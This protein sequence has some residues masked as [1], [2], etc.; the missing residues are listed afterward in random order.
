MRA[1]QKNQ[2]IYRL[3]A[4]LVVLVVLLP[5]LPF[6]AL[7]DAGSCGD[8]LTWY[9]DGI[10]LT[11]S[12][13]GR[14]SDYSEQ[15]PAP[16]DSVRDQ[17]L[18]I[19]LPNGLTK[20]GRRAF[21]GC[22]SVVS[23]SIPSSVE[24]IGEAA[25]CGNSNMKSLVL[26]EGL[27][28]VGNSAFELC[29]S[30]CEVQI[31]SS[32]EI[33][34]DHAFYCCENLMSLTILGNVSLFGTGAFSYC[35]NLLQVDISTPANQIPQWS[36]YGCD[37]LLQVNIQGIPVDASN[38]KISTLPAGQEYQNTDPAKTND[39]NKDITNSG[40]QD[41]FQNIDKQQD[42]TSETIAVNK[43]E[44]STIFND[45]VISN[46][47]DNTEID[48]DISA[49]VKNSEGFDEILDQI[50]IAETFR[51]V[52]ENN[53]PVEVTILLSETD[54]ITKD[55][56][57]QV[58]G[59]NVILNISTKT[60]AQIIINCR[61]LKSPMS[62]DLNLAYTLEKTEN[63]PDD[64]QGYLVYKLVFRSLPTIPGTIKIQMPGELS[65]QVASVYQ[66]EDVTK[67]Q[68]VYASIIDDNGYIQ[69]SKDATINRLEYLIGINIHNAASV[70]VMIPDTLQEE[71]NVVNLYD[72]VQYEIT[73][74]KS[75]W[76]MGLGKV[77]AILAVVM[78]SAVGV[79]GFVMYFWN[80][81]RLKAGYVPKW[82]DE[83][84]T[85]PGKK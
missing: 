34:G 77:M 72:G 79:I 65:R 85:D 36:F 59:K 67:A 64:L 71:Y 7:A 56:L 69:W 15:N 62:E 25:F 13:E 30:L 8:N 10:T 51:E 83:D 40:N 22:T 63:V 12:G 73:G 76:N 4:L 82:D 28:S 80:K 52:S 32:V 74:R 45:I 44:N 23:I 49:V 66:L 75:S 60:G 55:F 33:I 61:D 6:V 2:I 78:I 41:M 9:F 46:K 24:E 11:I 43:T 81:Q 58:A 26:S 16:W 70:N 1:R 31:P 53:K 19:S 38:Y 57:E 37:K 48:M 68:L 5:N 21:L 27:K 17:I 14:M 20:I 18:Q 29:T 3:L 54:V 47:E 50:E 39:A 35:G 84:E 42:N